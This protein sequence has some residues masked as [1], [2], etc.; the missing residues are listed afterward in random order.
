MRLAGSDPSFPTYSDREN[1]CGWQA[2][3][4]LFLLTLTV[5]MCVVGRQ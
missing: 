1:V 3:T 5:R 2:V 4:L